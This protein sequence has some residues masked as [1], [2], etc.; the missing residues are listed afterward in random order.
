MMKAKS[1]FMRPA[2]PFGLLRNLA[3]TSQ[4]TGQ[5]ICVNKRQPPG[6]QKETALLL[7]S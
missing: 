3:L 4:L 7:P 1:Y 2:V 5:M 6:M